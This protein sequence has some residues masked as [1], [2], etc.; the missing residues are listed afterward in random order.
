VARSHKLLFAVAL[1]AGGYGLALVWNATVNFLWPTVASNAVSG[2][3]PFPPVI[4][5]SG[6][7]WTPPTSARLIPES[8][9]HQTAAA[10]TPQFAAFANGA[11]SSS[12][13]SPSAERPT[14]VSAGPPAQLVD[15]AKKPDGQLAALNKLNNGSQQA[16]TMPNGPQTN[17]DRPPDFASVSPL[18]SA[19]ITEVKPVQE[20]A[21]ADASPWDRWP[22]WDPAVAASASTSALESN[23]SEHQ[24]TAASAAQAVTP[25][26]SQTT[27]QA[28]FSASTE[29]PMSRLQVV[30][31]PVSPSGSEDDEPRTHTIIDGDSLDKL[32]ARFLGDPRLGD[33]IYQLN[34]DVLKSPELLPIGVDIELP[35]RPLAD[36][37]SIAPALK[38]TPAA[39]AT[40]PDL[41]PVDDVRNA[42]VGMPRA[43]LLRPLPPIEETKS[44]ATSTAYATSG[45]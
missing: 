2:N 21:V 14:W 44:P 9:V 12:N 38:S 15:I 43:Q 29:H 13:S 18:V 35:P 30:G 31:E 26:S 22:R 28:S 45:H 32:A 40:S 8:Q 25:T 7:T 1:L 42:F 16:S 20:A 33:E 4:S 3:Q 36:A 34:R 39:T 17:S 23:A 6:V 19:R 10:S 41:V 24:V 37:K 11:I 5:T 27:F